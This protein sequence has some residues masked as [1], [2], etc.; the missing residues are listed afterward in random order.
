MKLEEHA[1]LSV[2]NRQYTDTYRLLE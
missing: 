1:I 2:A